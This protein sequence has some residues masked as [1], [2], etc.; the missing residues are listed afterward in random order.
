MRP[1][2]D[3]VTLRGVLVMVPRLGW[4]RGWVF[5]NRISSYSAASDSFRCNDSASHRRPSGDSGGVSG[6][7]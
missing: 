3:N 5:Y 1:L 6:A 2:Q 4:L 7:F